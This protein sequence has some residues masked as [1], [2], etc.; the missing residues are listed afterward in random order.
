MSTHR[1]EKWGVLQGNPFLAPEVVGGIRLIGFREDNAEHR[2]ITSPI[3][4]V[5][6]RECTTQSGS[7]YILGEV[8]EDYIT[9]MKDHGITYDPANPIKDRR[10]GAPPV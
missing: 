9:W 1:L 7:V 6:G 2:V 5:N 10:T 8:A 4:K 3:V